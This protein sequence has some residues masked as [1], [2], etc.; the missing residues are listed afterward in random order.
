MTPQEYRK[1]RPGARVWSLRPLRNGH[2]EVPPGAE[3]TVTF[4]R[5]GL[6]VRFDR[7]DTCGVRPLVSRIPAGH[8]S[9]QTRGRAGVTHRVQWHIDRYGVRGSLVCDAP[10]GAECRMGCPSGCESWPCDHQPED[11]GECQ[12]LPWIDNSEVVDCYVGERAPVRDGPIVLEWTG[13]GY[14]WSYPA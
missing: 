2:F 9:A 8:L 3:G 13:E 11:Q 1:I 7:C 12:I 4:K 14:D 10:E 6:D 5:S